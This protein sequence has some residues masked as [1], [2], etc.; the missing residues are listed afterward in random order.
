MST[1]NEERPEKESLTALLHQWSSGSEVAEREVFDLVYQELHRLARNAMRRERKDHTLQTTALVN[2]AYVRL[3]QA[4]LPWENRRHFY[5]VA[6]RSMRRILVDH[7]RERARQKRGGNAERVSLDEVAVVSPAASV[8]LV[9][10]DE[11]L[12][13]LAAFDARKARVIELFYFGG[14]AYDEIGQV[15]DVSTATV[16]R[17]LRMAKAWLYQQL[18]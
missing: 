12:D 9:A 1:T 14:L 3:V 7:A 17:D 16:H 8:D 10:L 18:H 13:R 5:A 11:A 15:V 6:A 2:E 4:N